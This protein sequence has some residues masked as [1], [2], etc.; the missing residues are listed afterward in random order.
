MTTIAVPTTTHT[1]PAPSALS[2]TTRPSRPNPL[3]ASATHSWRAWLK[4]K[5][6]L[7]GMLV[8][9]SITPLMVLLIFTYLFGGAFAGSTG[10]YLQFFLPGVMVQ[11]VILM[12]VYTGSFLSIDIT[13]GIF[14]RFRTMP[15]WQ[16]ASI[17]GNVA[18]DV[19]RYTT[20]MVTVL[21]VGLVMGFRAKGGV[22][23]VL[24]AMV[25][26][27]VFAFSVSWIFA[28]LGVV[29]KGPETVT[30]TTMIAMYPLMFTSN[31]FVDPATMP[32]W[33]QAVVKVNPISHAT[34]AV[35]G[36]MHGT[37]TTAQIGW[38]LGISALLIVVFAP[39]TMH[40]YARKGKG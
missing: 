34:T 1:E 8:E 19:L 22:D 14:N 10:T 11:S 27:L 2:R 7:A 15:F 32:G 28:A 6:N 13:K 36:F 30:G 24:L 21:G 20:A 18:S 38:V 33:M 37:I 25:V 16:P 3:T 12:T 39:L 40:L 29:A 35:R 23:G 17:V 5:H 26:L 9:T 4:I 31:I